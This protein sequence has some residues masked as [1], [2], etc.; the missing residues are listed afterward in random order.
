MFLRAGQ[1]EGTNLEGILAKPAVQLQH[2]L[3]MESHE[4]VVARA[5]IDGH[6]L[7]DTVGQEAPRCLDG[8]KFII[9]RY[10]RIDVGTWRTEQLTDLE[11]ITAGLSIQGY[12]RSRIIHHEIVITQTAVNDDTFNSTVIHP[13]NISRETFKKRKIDVR[14]KGSGSVVIRP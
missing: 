3:V 7:A 14:N 10:I 4:Q 13:L 5:S 8:G 11:G 12:F 2:C 9:D 6:G 1:G